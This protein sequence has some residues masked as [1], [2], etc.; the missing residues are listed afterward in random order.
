MSWGIRYLISVRLL[1]L[2]RNQRRRPATRSATIG[3]FKDDNA[4]STG[5]DLS[6]VLGASSKNFE[7]GVPATSRRNQSLATPRNA[8]QRRRCTS[9][10]R[11]RPAFVLG[12][13]DSPPW[14]RQRRFPGTTL[15]MH[16][17]PAL[18]L[19]QHLG[20]NLRFKGSPLCDRPHSSI[21]RHQCRSR[22]A[23]SEHARPVLGQR[24]TVVIEQIPCLCADISSVRNVRPHNARTRVPDDW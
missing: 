6:K 12:P 9:A 1:P 24:T 8:F 18:V 14:N 22:Q 13:V 20:R 19:A 3:A 11:A 21:W 10:I 15:M 2:Q 17:A 23:P 5:E 16:G 7:C 4:D